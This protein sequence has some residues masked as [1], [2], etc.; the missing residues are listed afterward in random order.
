[1]ADH[2]ASIARGKISSFPHL[3]DSGPDLDGHHL[4]RLKRPNVIQPLIAHYRADFALAVS[5][6]VRAIGSLDCI[7][8]PQSRARH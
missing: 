6:D 2:L 7:R 4:F 1:M 3:L 5:S 8:R